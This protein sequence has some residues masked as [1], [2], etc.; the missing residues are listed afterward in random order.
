MTYNPTRSSGAVTLCDPVVSAS[1]HLH[2]RGEFDK[3]LEDAII[4]GAG[5]G[6]DRL[7]RGRIDLDHELNSGHPRHSRCR[8]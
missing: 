8:R 4:C 3:V 7:A 2:N 5:A 6:C 1:E